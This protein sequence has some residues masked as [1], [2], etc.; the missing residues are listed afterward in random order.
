MGKA[1]HPILANVA[2]HKHPK[3]RAWLARHPR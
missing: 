2:T 1:I 3:V